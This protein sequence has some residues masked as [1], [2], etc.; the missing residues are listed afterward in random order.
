MF[1]KYLSQESYWAQERTAEQTATAIKNSLPF[2]VYKGEDQ[3]GFARVVTD[4]ATFAYLGD[5]FVLPEYQGKGLGKFLM[6]TILAHPDLQNFRRWILATRD[7]HAL[8]EKYEFAA[9]RHPE[10]WMERTAPNAY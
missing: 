6:R 5:V 9:L 3:V 7:A 8:Y 1:H 2:G 4:Y 10:R